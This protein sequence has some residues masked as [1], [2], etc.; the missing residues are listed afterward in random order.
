VSGIWSRVPRYPTQIWLLF[1]G[2]LTGSIGQSIVWPFLVIVIRER[3]HVPLTTV[4]LLFTLQSVAGFA[5]TTVLGPMMDRFGRKRAMLV[6]LISSGLVLAAMSQANTLA[7]WAVLLPAYGMVN[8]MFR[9]GSYAMVADLVEPQ[10]RADTYAL[11]R[12]GDNLGIVIGPTIGA[13][14]ASATYALSYLLAASTQFILFVFVVMIVH[15]TLPQRNPSQSGLMLTPPKGSSG[16]GPLLHDWTF[17]RVWGLY[18]LVNIASSMVFVLLG[19]YMKENFGIQ[20][21][22]YGKVIG[23]NA[24]MVVLFQFTVTRY[25]IK[26]SPLPI[27]GIGALFYASGLFI[28]AISQGFYGFLFGMMVMTCGELMISPTTTALVAN[29]APPEMRARYMGA[30]ALSF[31]VG[32]GIGPVLGGLLSDNIAPVAIWYGGM[33]FCL[34]AAA[35]YFILVRQSSANPA[36][37]PL[38]LQPVSNETSPGDR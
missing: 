23:A 27:I 7:M 38:Q 30:F 14:L 34:I 26:H 29:I 20:E 8:T 3:V 13:F 6:G 19:A 33:V 2:T 11:L 10:R 9:I 24:A 36:I 21:N 12:M 35:G 16:Y 5:A 25:T 15:E 31:R 17:L 4:T 1:W 32:A 22:D 37:Q 28:Y 18:I